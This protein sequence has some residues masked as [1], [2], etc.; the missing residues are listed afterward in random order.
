[1]NI[2][3]KSMKTKQ[4]EQE[5]IEIPVNAKEENLFH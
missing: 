1:L 4:K 2:Q 3:V 5:I